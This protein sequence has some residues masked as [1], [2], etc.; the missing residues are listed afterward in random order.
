VSQSRAG[1]REAALAAGRSR[2]TAVLTSTLALTWIA[3]AHAASIAAPG[4]IA[5]PDGG[6]VTA[7]PSA[8]YFNPAALGGTQ[9]VNVLMDAQAAFIHVEATATRNDRIDP[10]TGSAYDPMV[11]DVIVPVGLLGASWKAIPERLAVGIA[12]YDP[13]A[14]GGIYLDENGEPNTRAHGRYHGV[15]VELFSLAV[16]PAVAVTVIEGLHAGGGVTW[17]YDK[18]DALQAADPLGTEGI[19]PEQLDQSP[20]ED[21]YG[22]DVLLDASASGSHW[23]WNAG[24]M[25]NRFPLLQA[26]ASYTSGGTF[27]ATGDATVDLPAALSTTGEATTIPAKA[28]FTI[29]LPPIARLYLASQLNEKLLIGAGV[30]YEMWNVCCGTE[31]TDVHV[32]VTNKDGEA[33][34]ADDGSAIGIAKDQYNPARTWNAAT[35]VLYGGYQLTPALWLGARGEYNQYAVPD[36]SV[37]AVNLDFENVGAMLGARYK[38]GKNLVLGVS[39]SHFFLFS[40]TITDSAWDRRDGNERFSPELPYKA[41]ANGTYSGYANNV[42][43]RVAANF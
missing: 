21:P 36:Y 14:G 22:Y 31:E 33:I 39:Y 8:I 5:T 19:S 43:L 3:T 28:A 29:E 26:G 17:N 30:N 41:N 7:D 10:N 34:G 16:T 6:A 2:E 23:S 32:V 13:F 35:F 37:N 20:P 15:A 9:G 25:F 1:G 42:G 38:I 12:A 27:N 4:V 11:A 24:V 40:R 18:I